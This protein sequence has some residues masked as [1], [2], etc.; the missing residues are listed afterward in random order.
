MHANPE[1]FANLLE[2][3]EPRTPLLMLDMVTPTTL[4]AS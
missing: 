3:L 1:Q 2:G 4:R